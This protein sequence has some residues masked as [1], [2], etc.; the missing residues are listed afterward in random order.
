MEFV[1]LVRKPERPDRVVFEDLQG[2]R[3]ELRG[4]GRAGPPDPR[5]P[6]ADMRRI[7]ER[8]AAGSVLGKATRW[9]PATIAEEVRL[10]RAHPRGDGPMSSRTSSQTGSPRARVGFDVIHGH[11]ECMIAPIEDAV[12]R[13]R[14]LIGSADS[15]RSPRGGG[16]RDA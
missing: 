16:S 5:G 9:D 6:P 15:A 7:D 4:A 1:D 13:L 8:G 10:D 12:Q 14:P 3:P 2:G 11:E